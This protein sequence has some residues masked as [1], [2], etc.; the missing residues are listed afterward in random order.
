MR[1]TIKQCCCQLR[2]AK[3]G[4]PLR[5]AQVGG[6]NQTGPFIELAEQVE[7]QGTTCL[8]KRQVTKFIKD[9][10]ID[11]GESVCQASVPGVELFQLERIDQFDR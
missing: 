2:I 8:A 3:D 7:Q 4:R 9:N 1:K 11:M 5:E 6:D 10:E